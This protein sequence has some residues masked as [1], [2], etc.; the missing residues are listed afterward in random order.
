M[1]N[2]LFSMLM[3][4][5]LLTSSHLAYSQS[6]VKFRIK[7]AGFTVYGSFDEFEL[8]VDYDPS[9]LSNS[10]FNGTV[11]VKSI[12]TNNKA[13]DKHLR[14]EDFFHVDKWPVMKFRSN[15]IKK[16]SNNKIQVTGKLSIKDV[17]KLITFEVEVSQKSGKY[18]FDTS[19]QIDRLD[20]N[21]GESS[22]T[23]ANKLYI[24]L[25]VED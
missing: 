24:D 23:L 25:H 2:R 15:Y 5:T 3:L 13:R 18:I 1:N 9:D 10:T 12:D 11:K 20:Y 4:I 6:E 7:N 22:W 16:I 17:T 21:V 14:N 8:D 19:L